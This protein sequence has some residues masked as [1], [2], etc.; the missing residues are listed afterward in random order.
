MHAQIP[1]A[2][3]TRMLTCLADVPNPSLSILRISL[4]YAHKAGQT[5]VDRSRY[6]SNELA[7]LKSFFH[8]H[9]GVSQIRSMYGAY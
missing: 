8:S 6:L 7:V 1:K 2:L 3:G 5:T 4:S 9:N